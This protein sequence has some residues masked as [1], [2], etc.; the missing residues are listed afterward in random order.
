V[1][2]QLGELALALML[3]ISMLSNA[4]EARTGRPAV[5]PENAEIIKGPTSEDWRGIVCHA[6]CRWRRV[7]VPCQGRG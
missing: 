5:D 4:A 2:K 7:Q 6:K 1:S 3:G